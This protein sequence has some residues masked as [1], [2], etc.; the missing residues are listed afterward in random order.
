MRPS[1]VLGPSSSPLRAGNVEMVVDLTHVLRSGMPV[2][3]GT[4]SPTFAPSN[5]ID[6]DGFAE[7]AV[8]MCT[9]TGTHIDA[10]S[11]IIRG[12]KSLDEFPIDYFTGP[13]VLLDVSNESSISRE[14]IQPFSSKI[15]QSHFVVFRTGWEERW[16]TPAY[17][18]G[19]PTLTNEAAR[20]LASFRL[21][22]VG[23]DAISV[24]GV[25]DSSLL[26]HHYLL[27][28]EVLIIEN[29]ANLD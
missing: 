8:T 15:A 14:T 9:H 1:T 27:Q 22:A 7:L 26:N 28:R 16:G 3:P 20:W 11:H 17:F 23:F 13:A 6:Q 2:Y 21:H 19:F 4:I 12:A 18:E 29:L 10:P 5:T 25:A 24:D